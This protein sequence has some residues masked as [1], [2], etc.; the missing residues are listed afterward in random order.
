MSGTVPL[1][2]TGGWYSTPGYYQWVIQYTWYYQWVI[3]YP[4]VLPVGGIVPL[5]LPV[6][7]TV[8]LGATSGWYSTPGYYQWVVGTTGG[9]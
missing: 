2:T 4:W 5:V 7:D 9:W 3:Q 6:G 1:G 8:P